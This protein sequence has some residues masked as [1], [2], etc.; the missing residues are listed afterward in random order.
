MTPAIVLLEKQK[1]LS[2]CTIFISGGKRGLNIELAVTDLCRLL[3][4]FFGY[5]K[6]GLPGFVIASPSRLC[7]IYNFVHYL[8]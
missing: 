1:F 5:C 6:A 3:Q 4:F 2:H 7:R 8:L